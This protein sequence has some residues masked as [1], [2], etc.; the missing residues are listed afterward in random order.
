MKRKFSV[1]AACL[2]ALG[3]FY[4][5]EIGAQ[6]PPKAYSIEM[7]LQRSKTQDVYDCRITVNHGGDVLAAPRVQVAVGSEG[8]I[9]SS[10]PKT[11][12]VVDVTV[13]SD[14]ESGALTYTVE[15]RS[16]GGL[17]MTRHKAR[18]QT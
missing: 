11:G 13:V 3:A 16:A 18:V 17:L 1:L 6:Q 2:I 5:P 12:E 8:Q 15:I 14:S 4:L 10:N 9:R 7:D